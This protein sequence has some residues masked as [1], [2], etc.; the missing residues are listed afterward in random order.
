MQKELLDFFKSQKLMAVASGEGG[1][2][3]ANVY[4]GID[5][6][7]KLYFIS[8]TDTKHSRQILKNPRIAFSVAWYDPKN[9]GNRKAV[10]GLGTC[11]LADSTEE[12]IK[13]VQLHNQSFPEFASTITV[14]WIRQN[15]SDSRVWAVEPSYIK[16]WNDELYGEEET[17]EFKLG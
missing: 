13:G 10:Q 17:E 2:W 14:Q 1:V 6:D 3:I 9:P 7:F 12:I 5:D 11:R 4:Y 16:F 15:E 8:P